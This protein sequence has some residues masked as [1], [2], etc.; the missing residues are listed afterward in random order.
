MP[1]PTGSKTARGQTGTGLQRRAFFRTC[2]AR[3]STLV[4]RANLF[5]RIVRFCGRKAGCFV[6]RA[7]A[8]RPPL[9]LAPQ[10]IVAQ[11]L[12]RAQAPLLRTPPDFG[13]DI[14]V[15]RLAGVIGCLIAVFLHRSPNSAKSARP[16]ASRPFARPCPICSICSLRSATSCGNRPSLAPDKTAPAARCCYSSGVEHS[17]GKGEAES[18]NLSSSTIF[19]PSKSIRC[20]IQIRV[21]R[22]HLFH[23]N[24]GRHAHSPSNNETRR[25]LWH[26]AAIPADIRILS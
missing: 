19:S 16:E 15:R 7:G 26:R 9:L 22:F 8:A 24:Y 2:K 5:G 10:E 21:W 13:A 20:T 11:R 14:V 12:C 1:A 17:L 3:C 18:S 23:R 4:C 25:G 6:G